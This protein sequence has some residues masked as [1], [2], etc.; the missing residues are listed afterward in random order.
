[1]SGHS[2]RVYVYLHMIV[3]PDRWGLANDV[4][5]CEVPNNVRVCVNVWGMTTH[6]RPTQHRGHVGMHPYLAFT[7]VAVTATA[8][9][10]QQLPI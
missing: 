4:R 5:V 1:M 8:V 2:D 10:C 9:K 3:S 6:I 7:A